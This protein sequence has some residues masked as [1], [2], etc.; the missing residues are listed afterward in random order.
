MS[1]QYPGLT[2]AIFYIL[3]GIGIGF[4][5]SLSDAL[6]IAKLGVLFSVF[7]LIE[8]RI[9]VATFRGFTLGRDNPRSEGCFC[10]QNLPPGRHTLTIPCPKHGKMILVSK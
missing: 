7:L 9:S 5:A 4:Y 2:R 10:P 8:L 3:F 6:I 1:Y